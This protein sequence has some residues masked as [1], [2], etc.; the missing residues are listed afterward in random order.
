MRSSLLSVLLSVALATP[1]LADN[2][3]HIGDVIIDADRNMTSVQVN[4]STPELA[5]L[6]RLAFGAH[7]AYRLV[8]GGAAYSLNFT[9]VAP[10]QVRVEIARGS[11]GQPVLN[12]V[13]SGT[14]ARNAL[15]RAADVAVAHTTKL[16]GFFAGK[17]AFISDRGHGDHDFRSVRRRGGGLAG[18]EPANHR[19]P[20]VA[21][22]TPA[23]LHQFSQRISG[24]L[25]AGSDQPSPRPGDTCGN[26][27]PEVR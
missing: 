18:R 14:S 13:V 11:A 3:T 17:L 26:G 21:G 22:R 27:R 23:D 25:C 16:R 15:L 10:T 5:N 8:S 7:G 9:L 24:H 1:V 4:A 2:A 12:Q 19:A 20:L 6:A